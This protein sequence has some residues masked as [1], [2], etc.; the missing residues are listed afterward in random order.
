MGKVLKRLGLGIAA[1][2]LSGIV[3]VSVLV[4]TGTLPYKVY[5]IHT[6]SMYP[7]FPVRTAVIVREHRYHI[8][9]PVSFVLQ[10]GGAVITHRLVAINAEGMITTKGDANKTVDPWHEPKS[11]IIGGVVAAPPMVG[12]LIIFLRNPMGG[13]SIVL[14]LVSF[15]LLWS[16]VHD[17]EETDRERS[18]VQ[19][20]PTPGEGP[21]P[22]H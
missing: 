22:A 11:Y 13:A 7:T 2:V 3:T 1:A 15:W 20:A 4:A 14:S 19:S 12:Y 9:Q 18:P 6:G 5:V 10:P 8:G 16:I 17:L 21:V